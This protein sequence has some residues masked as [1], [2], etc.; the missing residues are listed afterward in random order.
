MAAVNLGERKVSRVEELTRSPIL[1]ELMVLSKWM[2][3]IMILCRWS[4]VSEMLCWQALPYPTPSPSQSL[5]VLPGQI[6]H[7][8][9]RYNQLKM[10]FNGVTI[11]GF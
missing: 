2:M 10:T 9:P 3:K 1:D 6:H 11:L 4:L 5:L 8:P 7:P